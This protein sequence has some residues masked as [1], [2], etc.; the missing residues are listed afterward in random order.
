MNKSK[1][2]HYQKLANEYE[3]LAQEC[4]RVAAKFQNTSVDNTG[5]KEDAEQHR[6]TSA[7]YAEKAEIEMIREELDEIWE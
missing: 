7:K 6:V 5:F 4:D 2:A 3:L 1:A